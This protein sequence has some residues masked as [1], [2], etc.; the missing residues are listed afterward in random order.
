MAES[1]RR[2]LLI[3]ADMRVGALTGATS[4]GGGRYL[5]DIL[6]GRSTMAEATLPISENLAFIGARDPASPSLPRYAVDTVDMQAMIYRAATQYDY[7][8]VNLPPTAPLADLRT[9]APALDAVAAVVRWRATPQQKAREA[10]SA[11]SAYPGRLVGVILTEI[12]FARM[13][14]EAPAS[15]IA[16]R[17]FE[18]ACLFED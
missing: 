3:D 12:E 5:T 10:V 7:V 1:G 4:R 11:L 2:T 16:S 17:S 18:D 6:S 14:A 8:V 13:D 15:R 9:M